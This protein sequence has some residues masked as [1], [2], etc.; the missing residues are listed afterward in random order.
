METLKQ[1]F[2]NFLRRAPFDEY[3]HNLCLFLMQN[4]KALKMDNN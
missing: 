4:Q 3:Q 1:D 2:L